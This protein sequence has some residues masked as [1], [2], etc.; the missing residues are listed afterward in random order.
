LAPEDVTAFTSS[1]GLIPRRS[2]VV[3]RRQ[4]VGGFG[5]PVLYTSTVTGGCFGSPRKQGYV[6][7]T[8]T[9]AGIDVAKAHL[10]V[11]LGS[12]HRRFPNS[13]AGLDQLR[14]FIGT[15]IAVCEASGGYERL[16]ARSGL[17]VAVVNPSRVRHYARAMGCLAKTDS[18]D[19]A[20]IARF[21]EHAQPLP[22]SRS[23][24]RLAD[25]DHLH[26][27]LLRQQQLLRQAEEHGIYPELDAVKASV[28]SQLAA[29]VA[30]MTKLVQES[31]LGP[32]LL[33]IPGI[34]PKT[35]AVLLAH[36]PELGSGSGESLSAL[37]GLAP[38]ARDSGSSS[39]KRFIAGGRADVRKALYMATVSAVRFNPVI[40]PFYKRLRAS[41]KSPKVA[42]VACMRKLL[43]ILH[44][45]A[46]NNRPFE[47]KAP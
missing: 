43:L 32:L 6:S 35:V 46:K 12:T 37:V 1:G 33:T 14:S 42:L 8:N 18:I 44:S 40:G 38:F 13:R 36:L 16:L 10:D 22:Q 23:D 15:S 29:V 26:Q 41:G 27:V 2:L 11:A 21:A 45:V 31:R 25:L 34:G 4:K 39:G 19:A 9:F 3:Y 7:M 5:H 24:S 30:E 47:H 20:V 28:S 17:P